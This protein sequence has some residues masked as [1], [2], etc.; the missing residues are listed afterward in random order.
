MQLSEWITSYTS[1]TAPIQKSWPLPVG[2]E[3]HLCPSFLRACCASSTPKRVTAWVVRLHDQ[4]G[5]CPSPS[6]HVAFTTRDVTTLVSDTHL[7]MTLLNA[8]SSILALYAST[9][10]PTSTHTFDIE[11]AMR[12]FLLHH[13]PGGSTPFAAPGSDI[14]DQNLLHHIGGRARSRAVRLHAIAN[15]NIFEVDPVLQYCK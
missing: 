2:R 4:K 12:H 11:Q 15:T 14:F 5:F 8:L 13:Q 10:S 3:K 7:R 6:D 1:D 9:I